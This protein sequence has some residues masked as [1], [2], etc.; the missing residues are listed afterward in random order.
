MP[1]KLRDDIGSSKLF[2]DY[3]RWPKHFQEALEEEFQLNFIPRAER[4]VFAGMGGSAVAGDIIA[5]WLSEDQPARIEVVKDYHLPLHMTRKSLVITISCSGNTEETVSVLLEALKRQIPCVAV[6]SGGLLEQVSQ[7]RRVPFIKVKALSSPRS[8][9][10]FMLIPAARIALESLGKNAKE[11]ELVECLD[12]MRDVGN[13]TSTRASTRLNPAAMLAKMTKNCQ[14]I[15]YTPLTLKAAAIRFKNSLNENAKVHSSVEMLPELCH[16]ELEAWIN[17]NRTWLP[18]LLRSKKE[19]PEVNQRFKAVQSIMR[20]NGAKPF[21]AWA[22]G[23]TR[24]SKIMS[25]LYLLDFST[26]YLAKLKGLN[27]LPTPNIDALKKQ[28]GS[29]LRYLERYAPR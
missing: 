7:K 28:L 13:Q 19:P 5:D 23:S 11:R 18:I 4:L 6:S 2:Q 9:L 10:P 8:S 1:R 24:L 21:E 22:K 12:I 16:N 3:D 17:N 27:P 29:N 20:N 14:P 15:I 25:L 26:L